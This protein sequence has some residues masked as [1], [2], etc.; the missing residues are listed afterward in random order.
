MGIEVPPLS[1]L[2]SWPK[3]NYIN[4]VT[5]G[6]ETYVVGTVFLTLATSVVATRLYARV[7]IRRWFGLDDLFICLAWVCFLLIYEYLLTLAV[8][9]G[10]SGN[11]CLSRS[12]ERRME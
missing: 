7:H 6:P 11:R 4:P 12:L 9:I 8:I 10:R 2:L 1:V 3:P 5:R